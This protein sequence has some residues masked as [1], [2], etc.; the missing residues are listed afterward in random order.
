MAFLDNIMCALFHDC[1]IQ[2]AIGN[3]QD[4]LG[5]GHNISICV[6]CIFHMCI[7]YI[8]IYILTYICM[9]DER[10]REAAIMRRR[11]HHV[12]V[13]IAFHICSLD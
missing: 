1:Y 10:E 5:N 13:P 6:M 2:K 9:Y 7:S 3:R 4:A 11:V 8:D 12:C